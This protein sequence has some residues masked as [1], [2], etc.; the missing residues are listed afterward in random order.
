MRSRRHRAVARAGRHRLL[1]GPCGGTGGQTPIPATAAPQQRQHRAVRQQQRR[2]RQGR[3]SQAGATSP[4]SGTPVTSAI[5]KVPL[6]PP[7]TTV[8]G[9]V[10]VLADNVRYA[11]ICRARSIT[12]NG[13]DSLKTTFPNIQFKEEQYS[14]NE[15]LDKLRIVLQ[16]ESSA[17]CRRVAD[18][19]GAGVLGAGRARGDQSP[20]TWLL[21]RQVLAGRLEVRHMERQTVRRADE[22]RDARLHLEQGDLPE[23]R[24]RSREAARDLGRC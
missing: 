13:S 5:V 19:L 14:Y 1:R 8:K 9:S 18:P 24:A 23:G 20:G 17:G 4:P 12:T 16:G 22:Q 3:P 10:R 7:N 2:G 21:R 6:N 15:M 11:H